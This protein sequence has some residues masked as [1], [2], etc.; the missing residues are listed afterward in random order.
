M[1][2]FSYYSEEAQRIEELEEKI[3]EL[4]QRSLLDRIRLRE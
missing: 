2:E 3:E 4:E 1:S